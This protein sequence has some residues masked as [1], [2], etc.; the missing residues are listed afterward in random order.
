[1]ITLDELT[2]ELTR[3]GVGSHEQGEGK[4]ARELMIE[5]G[6]PEQAV[7]R[8]LREAKDHDLLICVKQPRQAIDGSTRIVPTYSFK[9]A[10]SPR[11]KAG[12]K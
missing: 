7:M 11:M 5:W 2:A 4:T 3:L 8:I 9:V 6:K 1:M 12:K 10:A